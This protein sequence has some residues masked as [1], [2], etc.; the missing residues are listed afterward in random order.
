MGDAKR[1]EVVR[2]VEVLE[3]EGAPEEVPEEVPE[4]GKEAGI[5][6]LYSEDKGDTGESTWTRDSVSQEFRHT[7]EALHLP[8]PLTEWVCTSHCIPIK[9]STP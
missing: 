4:E 5:A 9:G 3:E 6:G 7:N 2:G 8:D 1:A